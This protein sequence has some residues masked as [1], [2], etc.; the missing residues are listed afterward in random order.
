LRGGRG[1][2]AGDDRPEVEVVD[3]DGTDKEDWDGYVEEIPRAGRGGF[4]LYAG[5]GAG[6]GL[7][8]GSGDFPFPAGIDA[9]LELEPELVCLGFPPIALRIIPSTKD[10]VLEET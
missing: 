5:G 7:R 2:G 6:L 10:T 3:R 4:S 8:D 1:G 9:K